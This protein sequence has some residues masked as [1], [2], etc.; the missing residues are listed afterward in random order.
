MK[1]ECYN[2]E[3]LQGKGRDCVI[4]KGLGGFRRRKVEGNDVASLWSAEGNGVLKAREKE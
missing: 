2:Q 4:R 3:A 1:S